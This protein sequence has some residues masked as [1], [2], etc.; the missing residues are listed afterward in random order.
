MYLEKIKY[1]EDVK[2]S[3]VDFKKILKKRFD[4][5]SDQHQA[6]VM[7]RLICH[8][9]DNGIQVYAEGFLHLAEDAY[10]AD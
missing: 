8:N 3:W 10:P 9:S 2:P 5:I 1:L 4:D 6:L 7:L